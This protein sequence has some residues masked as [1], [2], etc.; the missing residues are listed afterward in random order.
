MLVV[1][2]MTSGFSKQGHSISTLSSVSKRH[3]GAHQDQITQTLVQPGDDVVVSKKW[4]VGLD[5]VQQ[6]SND[7]F[8]YVKL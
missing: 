2:V 1:E 5:I 6:A 3:W 8:L 4:N 7:M